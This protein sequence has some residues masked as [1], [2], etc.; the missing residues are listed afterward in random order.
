MRPA[1]PQSVDSSSAADPS[2]APSRHSSTVFG[3]TLGLGFDRVSFRH[4]PHRFL[5]I[6]SENWVRSAKKPGAL[7]CPDH[8]ARMTA[9]S[10]GRF[11][12][13]IHRYQTHVHMALGT[14]SIVVG[15]ST[16]LQSR[17]HRRAGSC[18]PRGARAIAPDNLR[19]GALS[20]INFL[21]FDDCRGM[22]PGPARFSTEEPTGA[23]IGAVRLM[24]QGSTG[25][26][27]W[28]GASRGPCR[29]AGSVA[30]AVQVLPPGVRVAADDRLIV[31]N[32]HVRGVDDKLVGAWSLGRHFSGF[33]SA[34]GEWDQTA[35]GG[36]LKQA[37]GGRDLLAGLR[38]ES[39]S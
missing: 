38:C 23:A 29:Q 30:E 28:G 6:R 14:Y 8:Q 22:A 12:L 24:A 35:G 9:G 18:C 34:A 1:L 15:W 13:L 27:S 10:I 5:Y 36:P 25:W 31:A 2:G 26:A 17:Q 39:R 20:C 16:C 3:C 7:P 11:L 21:G 19:V 4:S 37:G 32:R 33:L